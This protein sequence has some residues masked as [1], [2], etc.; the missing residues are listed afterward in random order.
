MRS[1]GTNPALAKNAI[2]APG[3]G[4]IPWHSAPVPGHT[5][6]AAVRIVRQPTSV[7]VQFVMAVAGSAPASN[8]PTAGKS[9]VVVP[10]T[11][12]AVTGLSARAPA[13]NTAS[14]TA[15]SARV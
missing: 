15:A 3:G 2:A 4:T 5:Q 11:I 9:V 7:P 13:A 1:I 12:G 8:T 10:P 14:A 6:W